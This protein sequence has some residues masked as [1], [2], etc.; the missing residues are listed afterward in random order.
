MRRI[1]LALAGALAILPFGSIADGEPG[2]CSADGECDMLNAKTFMLHNNGVNDGMKVTVS[3]PSN[4]EPF[5]DWVDSLAEKA[6]ASQTLLPHQVEYGFGKPY[7]LYT[8]SSG[9]VVASWENITEDERYYVVPNGLNFMW[10]TV[11][12][13]HTVVI[14]DVKTS[15]GKPIILRTINHSP[16][17]FEIENLLTEEEAD[18]LRNAALHVDHAGNKFQRSTTGHTGNVDPFRTS[19]NA[20]VHSESLVAVN[21]TKRAFEVIRMKYEAPLAD[22]IQVL[23]Y[24]ASGGYRWHTDWFPENT[25]Y[26][27]NHDVTRGGANRFATVFF[28]LSD[29][30]LGGQTGFPEAAGDTSELNSSLTL[31][32][33]MFE[34]NSWEIEAVQKCFGRLSVKPRKARA[35]LFYSLH[36]N[37]KGDSMSMHTGCPVLIG[38]K[39]AANLWIWN[40]DRDA[41]KEKERKAVTATFVND[42]D[43]PCLVS[44]V[45]NP[46][47]VQGRIEPGQKMQMNTFNTDS[48]VFRDLDRVKVLAKWTCDLNKGESQVV[49]IQKGMDDKQTD[50]D[51]GTGP[52]KGDA[53][54]MKVTNQYPHAIDIFWSGN[55]DQPLMTLNPGGSNIV[56]T[57]HTHSFLVFKSGEKAKGG[58]ASLMT[59]TAYKEAGQKQKLNLGGTVE[60]D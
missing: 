53:V 31:A 8:G 6:N 46:R 48:F 20:F 22:G 50:D 7:K 60:L 12:V 39:W 37:G 14:D 38:Q 28:Y 5:Q 27:R 23:R 51:W 24:N 15:N 2:Q 52:L 4:D 34:K 1:L 13:N 30:E 10:P 35:I 58:A 55:P 36:P 9:H 44:W 45:T 21:L 33:E 19:D 43:V 56:Q 11:D 40:K 16:R 47:H 41:E 18:A 26:G 59:F 54:H 49:H 17:L 3:K 29:V 57:Y 42:M 25:A 32:H